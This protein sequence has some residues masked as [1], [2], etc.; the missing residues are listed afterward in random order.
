MKSIVITMNISTNLLNNH[1]FMNIHQY[2]YTQYLL[3]YFLLIATILLLIFILKFVN[4]STILN[5][6]ILIYCCCTMYKCQKIIIDFLT[7]DYPLLEVVIA[8]IEYPF[9]ALK[10]SNLKKYISNFAT[11]QAF[12]FIIKI[13]ELFVTNKKDYIKFTYKLSGLFYKL[14]NLYVKN[15]TKLKVLN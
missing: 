3:G 1:T 2:V 6:I 15:E 12:Y 10:K 14:G 9:K 11:L 13:V 5:L 4:K 8:M 7:S